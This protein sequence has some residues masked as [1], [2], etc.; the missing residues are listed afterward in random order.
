MRSYESGLALEFELGSSRAQPAPAAASQAP[1]VGFT[2]PCFKRLVREHSRYVIGLLRRLGVAPG[3]VDD[4]AQD[5]FLAIHA[6]LARFEGR[7]SLKTWVCGIC[8]NKAGDYRRKNERRRGLLH[9]SPCEPDPPGDNPHDEL[10]RKEGAKRLQQAL[11]RLPDEQFEAFVLHELEELPM[12]DVA[13]A[14]GCPLDTAYT[15]HR[16]AREKVRAFFK[17]GARTDEER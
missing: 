9:A 11:A 6:Q 3:D 7:S 14:M 15:R 10:L 13:A 1:A 5:V 17:R 16:V 4:V 12:R 8:R 2:P